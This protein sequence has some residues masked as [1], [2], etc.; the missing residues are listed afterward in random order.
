M[1]LK[2]IELRNFTVF[3]DNDFDFSPGLNVFI[4]ANATGKSHLM[5]LLYSALWTSRKKGAS[6]GDLVG[7]ERFP[8]E[9]RLGAKLAAVFK[10]SKGLVQRLVTRRFDHASAKVVV[11][12]DEGGSLSFGIAPSGSIRVDE[13][14]LSFEEKSIF[15]PSREVLA[16]YEGFIAAYS[17]RELAF[18]ETYYD[19]CLALSLGMKK[20]AGLE[21]AAALIGDLDG[22]LG[23]SV[24]LE[25]GRFYVYTDDGIF[26]AQLMSEGLRKVASL[27]CLALNGSLTQNGFLFWDEPEANLNPRLVTKIA[28]VLRRLAAAGVQVFVATHDYLLTQ[29]LSLAAEYADQQPPELRCPIR[30]FALSRGAKGAVNAESGGTLAELPENPILDEFSALYDRRRSFFDANPEVAGTRRSSTKA[31][32]D[33]SLTHNGVLTGTMAGRTGI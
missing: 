30:F 11:R 4:G 16:L 14:N 3:E 7:A 29:E 6:G 18:D 20:W 28:E 12:N 8:L 9:S 1:K 2:R 33:S 15:I 26:E 21:S 23:G 13:K 27:V 24:E 32:C 25:G 19:L 17:E 5:K 31:N 22:V 10:P